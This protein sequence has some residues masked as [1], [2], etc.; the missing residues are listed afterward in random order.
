MSPSIPMSPGALS[1]SGL[2]GVPSDIRHG[3]PTCRRMELSKDGLAAGGGGH[4]LRPLEVRGSP[5]QHAEVV[6]TSP[7]RAA[8]KHPLLSHELSLPRVQ[9]A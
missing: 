3:G 2:P 7:G 5:E 8:G 9:P 4:L 1:L 6:R